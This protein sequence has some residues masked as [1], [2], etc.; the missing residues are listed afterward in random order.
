MKVTI[1]TELRCGLCGQMMQYHQDIKVRCVQLKCKERNK[2]YYAP[3][4]SLLRASESKEGSVTRP[5]SLSCLEGATVP[6]LADGV[7]HPADL[8]AT[9]VKQQWD[10]YWSEGKGYK[11]VK[12]LEEE[13]CAFLQP[14]VKRMEELISKAA[15]TMEK[16]KRGRPKTT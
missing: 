6:I 8:T 12:K 14:L 16:P 5:G 13:N 11:A 3:Q 2:E 7:E 4:I 10:E 1:H 9:N 15:L